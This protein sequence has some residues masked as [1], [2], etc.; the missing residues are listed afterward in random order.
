M[1]RSS[2][3]RDRAQNRDEA[4]AREGK[5]EVTRFLADGAAAEALGKGTIAVA[6]A[7][8]NGEAADPRELST[9]EAAV[10][11]QLAHAGYDTATHDGAGGQITELR[12]SHDVVVPQEAPHK[13]VSGEME[14]GVGNRGTSMGMAIAIDLSKPRKALVSTRLEA[15]IKDR[16]TGN[17]LWEGRADIATRDGSERWDD[18]AIAARLAAALFDG[19]PGRSGETVAAR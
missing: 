10:I 3:Q 7:P 6:A 17:V 9:Y 8:S 18:N 4:R 1:P 19:F 14:V 11:D 12:I 2:W 15:R 13:P 16:A 5:V